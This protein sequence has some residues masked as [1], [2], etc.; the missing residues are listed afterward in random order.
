M[1]VSSSKGYPNGQLTLAQ[2]HP[3][4]EPAR[5]SVLFCTN[6]RAGENQ[7]SCRS[8]AKQAS[9]VTP[10]WKGA[11]SYIRGKINQN[12]LLSHFSYSPKALGKRVG[13][14]ARPKRG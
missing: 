12:Q 13:A 1:D 9:K 2:G 5:F 8:L 14:G 6:F 10:G 7:E 11:G 4:I 3:E